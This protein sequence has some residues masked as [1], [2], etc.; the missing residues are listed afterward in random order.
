MLFRLALAAVLVCALSQSWPAFAAT[1]VGTMATGIPDITA[2]GVASD[3]GQ[4]LVAVAHDEGS[5]TA[6]VWALERVDGAWTAAMPQFPGNIGRKG[7]AAPGAKREGDG[8]SPYGAHA[9]GM[10][11]GV[12]AS[13]PARLPYRQMTD[14]DVWVD[15]PQADD[16]NV[17][18]TRQ[19]TRAKSYEDMKRKDDLY[20]WGLVV[21]YNTRTIVK[22][23]GSAI[24]VHL[25]GGPGK[26]TA[27]CLA[28]AEPRMLEI[29]RWLDPAK[30]PHV[31]FLPADTAASTASLR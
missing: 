15:D 23:H 29:L 13:C 26:P 24:F 31:V 21:E 14:A 5:S 2:V 12:A 3:V 30:K 10:V 27:G 25:W 16:Y 6:T 17:L 1:P 11:F 7:V 28:F 22:G 9:L 8:K 4:C 19:A 20:K 18:T